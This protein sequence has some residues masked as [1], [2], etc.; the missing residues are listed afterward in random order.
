M[1]FPTARASVRIHSN[2]SLDF[3]SRRSDDLPIPHA[4]PCEAQT[5][6]ELLVHLASPSRKGPASSPSSTSHRPRPPQARGTAQTG[7]AASERG[8][9][10]LQGVPVVQ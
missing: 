7:A 1:D 8:S 2:P 6:T 4:D 5:T 3:S 10:G 9:G